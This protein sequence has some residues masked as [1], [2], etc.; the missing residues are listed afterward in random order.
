M[1]TRSNWW[2]IPL[3]LALLLTAGCAGHART[4]GGHPSAGP[5]EPAWRAVT[6][7]AAGAGR[8]E[9]RDVA[10]CP[11]HW[12]AAGGYL[13]SDGSTRP[14]LWTSTD[15][16]RWAS[17][18][19]RPS[20]VYGPTQLLSA[21]ACRGGEVAAVGS[22]AGGAHANPRVST[23][24]SSGG[25]LDEVPAPFELYGG[26]DAIGV[27]RIAAG[28]TGWLITGTWWDANRQ[29]GAAVWFSPDGRSFRRVDADP[30]LESDTRGL[31]TAVDA[32]GGAVGPGAPLGNGSAAPGFTVVGNTITPGS[33][34]AARDPVVWTSPDGLSWRRVSV[35]ASAEDEAPER[36]VSYGGG[37][38]AVGERGGGF[39]AWLGTGG[40]WRPVGRFGRFAG[41]D[42]APLVTGLAVGAAQRAYALLG[43]G[44]R[45]RLW[46]SADLASWTELALP[47]TVPVG[48]Q[49][50]VSLTGTGGRLL[51]AAEDGS[52]TRVWTAAG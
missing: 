52:A 9:V 19:I 32:A 43:D 33:R 34:T 31:T 7:P 48:G 51:L 27:G 44:T 13:L 42:T 10:A 15:A 36:V 35:P 46:A 38:L 23:W 45:Y 3:S 2:R 17:V 14:A 21:V 16:Q 39:G 29:P 41:T 20:S 4:A 28:P 25:R 37:V 12:Y 11:G 49:R 5:T 26:P 24:F 6:L 8:V 30:A 1:G 47:A 18:P 22:T 40:R 50:L